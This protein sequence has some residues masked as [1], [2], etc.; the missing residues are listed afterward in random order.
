MTLKLLNV[1]DQLTRE[2]LAMECCQGIA[3][4]QTVATLGA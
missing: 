1:V 2:A 3:A 4:D